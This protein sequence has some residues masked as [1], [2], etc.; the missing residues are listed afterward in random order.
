MQQV[1]IGTEPANCRHAYT[2]KQSISF[3]EN[4]SLIRLAHACIALG[5]AA[6]LLLSL[7]LKP[8]PRGLGTHEQLFLFPCNFHAMTGLPCPFCGM[9]TAFAHMARGQ[10]REAFMA[11][12]MGALGFAVCALLLP[13]AIA[14]SITGRNAIAAAMKLPWGKISWVLAA[15]IAASWLFKLVVMLS[16]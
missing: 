1:G 3:S 9:T 15:M 12:P 8:D 14:A 13:V 5:L 10:V 16:R 4:K 11:Q 6:M 7:W 2:V